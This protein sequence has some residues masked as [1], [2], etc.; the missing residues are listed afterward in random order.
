VSPRASCSKDDDNKD[1][2]KDDSNDL[3]KNNAIDPSIVYSLTQTMFRKITSPAALPPSHPKVTHLAR[4][5]PL[6]TT[7]YPSLS[8]LLRQFNLVVEREMIAKEKSS[9]TTK[10]FQIL[11]K[12]RFNT[13]LPERN[14]L[15]PQL[16]N[17]VPQEGQDDND[18]RNGRAR[19]KVD[20]GGSA[21]YTII[22]E[23]VKGL[24]GV[25]V[26]KGDGEGEAGIYKQ[27]KKLN[28][29]E[30]VGDRGFS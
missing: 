23:C 24:G 10:T 4:L 13:L 29:G 28:Y 5:I 20:L 25:S 19:F 17:M 21:D 11:Y 7:F 12:S 6:V 8:M 30:F 14:V 2:S 18:K 15:I 3:R 22:V 27:W 26:V 1:D 9:K 16:A